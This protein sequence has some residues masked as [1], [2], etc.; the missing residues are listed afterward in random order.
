MRLIYRRHNHRSLDLEWHYEQ[1]CPRWPQADWI[2]GLPR[3]H[4]GRPYLHRLREA[5]T[6]KAPVETE[7]A[8][9]NESRADYTTQ[10]VMP[11]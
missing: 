9:R 11:N 5:L 4:G 3:P 8:A 1:K 6:Y 7:I 10:L 2:E